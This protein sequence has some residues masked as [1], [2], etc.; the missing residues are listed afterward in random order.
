MILN[1]DPFLSQKHWWIGYFCGGISLSI[2]L[3]CWICIT[4]VAE[5]LLL[6]SE[7]LVCWLQS[8]PLHV[9]CINDQF[10]VDKKCCLEGPYKFSFFFVC[11]PGCFWEF[12]LVAHWLRQSWELRHA[13]FC[14]LR[15]A[16]FIQVERQS[17]RLVRR[18]SGFLTRYTITY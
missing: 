14:I 17:R 6:L 10:H 8:S 5:K 16:I 7:P 12:S 4:M 3:P 1:S 9:R 18:I 15:C 11:Y 2:F 13:K